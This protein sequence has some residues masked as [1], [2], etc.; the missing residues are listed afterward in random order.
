[1]RMRG[2]GKKEEGTRAREQKT[3][4]QSTARREDCKYKDPTKV[5]EL[6][7]N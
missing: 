4:L 3:P 5:I 1:M 7:Q 2:K 6:Y